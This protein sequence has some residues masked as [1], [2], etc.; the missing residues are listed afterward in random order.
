MTNRGALWVAITVVSV[1]DVNPPAA[2]TQVS[3]RPCAPD[4]PVPSG[5]LSR[6]ERVSKQ[7]QADYDAF[8][9]SRRACR[10]SSDCA[11]AMAQCPLQCYQPVAASAVKEVEA[12]GEQLVAKVFAE[13]CGCSYK[14]R[15]RKFACI[16][17]ACTERAD[18]PCVP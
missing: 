17:G 18:P 7:A 10:V 2:G 4:V 11:L 12:F 16:K 9:S 14:C 15:L 1:L 6:C 3:K 5:P 13:H 8:L